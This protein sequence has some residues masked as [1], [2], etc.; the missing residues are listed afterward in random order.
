MFPSQCGG[1]RV[2]SFYITIQL[3]DPQNIPMVYSKVISMQSLWMLSHKGH[4]GGLYTVHFDVLE[5]EVG[6]YLHCVL[7]LGVAKV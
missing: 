4:R 6:I 2:S 3:G 1:S 7:L 5:T